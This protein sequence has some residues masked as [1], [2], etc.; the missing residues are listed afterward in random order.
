MRT[1]IALSCVVLLEAAAP[2]AVVP[3]ALTQQIAPSENM[4]AAPLSGGRA[5]SAA[6]SDKKI[7]KQLPTTG[8]RLRNRACLTAEQWKQL[9]DE[10]ED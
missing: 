6:P 10:L 7:C 1:L 2:A 8:S 4:T 5:A 3:Q 9:E